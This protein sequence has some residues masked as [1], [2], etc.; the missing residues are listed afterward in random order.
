VGIKI[1]SAF[2]TGLVISWFG[3]GGGVDVSLSDRI[4]VGVL[5]DSSVEPEVGIAVSINI[6]N[7]RVL[8]PPY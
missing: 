8:G 1:R 2:S 4:G 3:V 6:L 7:F 5:V